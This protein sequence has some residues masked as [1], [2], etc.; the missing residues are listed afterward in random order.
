MAR[1]AGI[2][3]NFVDEYFMIGTSQDILSARKAAEKASFFAAQTP[4]L[5]RQK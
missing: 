1:A 2:A 4:P 3:Q 5:W